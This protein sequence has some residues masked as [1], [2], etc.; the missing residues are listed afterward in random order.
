[1]IDDL[2][3]IITYHQ[4]TKHNLD[5]YAPG[6]HGL[7]WAT[8]P[9]P[10]RRYAAAPLIK[11][12]LIEPGDRPP[13]EPAFAEGR[14]PVQP[15][16][17]KSMSQLFFD[18]LAISAWKK[19]G[20]MSWAL[21]VNP[22]SGNLHPT[23]GYLVCGPI[24]GLCDSPTVC[25]YAPKSHA[26]ERRV[27]F[28]PEI[29]EAMTAQL[30]VDSIL[31]GLTSIHWREA[32]KYGERAFRYC[33]HDAG[34]AIATVSLAAAGLGW[35]A[36]LLDAL[37]TDAL[38]HLLGVFDPQDA[39]PEHPDCLLAIYPQ[40]KNGIEPAVPEET[41]ES[42]RGFQWQGR[43]NRLSPD[44]IDW[45]MI[46]Q[47]TVAT[48]KPA[49]RRIEGTV[50]PAANPL[51]IGP[52]DI[53]FR[54]IIHQRRSALAFNGQTGISREAF[55][56]ILMKTLPGPGQFPFNAI[57]WPPFIHLALFVHRVQDLDPGLYFLVRDPSQTKALQSAMKKEFA[58]EKPEDCPEGFE[59]YRL[60]TGDARE[61]S[62]Q[63]SCH[64]AIA[65]DGCFSLGM[66]ADFEKPLKEYGAWFYPRL[67]WESGVI[68][69]VLYL[70]AE[71]LGIRG[72]GI[73][74]Y[75]DDPM[76]SLLGLQDIRYQDLYHFTMGGH[77]E[78]PRLTTL[79]AYPSNL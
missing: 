8:Q 34:H 28:S 73:G 46:A 57:P 40:G 67:F 32:W 12:D 44:H 70:E 76:H 63:I 49:T 51:N 23:E 14:L 17:R 22:S 65:A 45:P 50:A 66:I 7:D 37:S 11:L 18:C 4:A 42:F 33:Q 75:F 1:M 21:R 27:E 55:Y 68:G 36:T 19:A 54:K 26:L 2:E 41:I 30:P 13:Y 29:W 9:D 62:Q 58:W 10:F 6:P 24:P 77:V 3:R 38:S 79:P 78:D 20:D 52:A 69:Q 5:R 60:L 72:T 48:R 59:F 71:A 53:S 15:L 39:E 61:I 16:D 25:H 64:Q 35:K 56:Q 31:V 47:A 43:P 74:C